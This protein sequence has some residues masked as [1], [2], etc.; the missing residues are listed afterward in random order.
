MSYLSKR[1]LCYLLHSRVEEKQAAWW[2][3]RNILQLVT[4]ENAMPAC[5]LQ[6]NKMEEGAK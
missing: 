4:R 1:K 3:F 6:L 2:F 5:E